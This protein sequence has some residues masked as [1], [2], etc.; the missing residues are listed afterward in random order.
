MLPLSLRT[1]PLARGAGCPGQGGRGGGL[2]AE[3]LPPADAAA[4]RPAPPSGPSPHGSGSCQMIGPYAI[5]SSPCANRQNHSLFLCK[6]G[7]ASRGA[8]CREGKEEQGPTLPGVSSWGVRTSPATSVAQS[9]A[10]GEPLLPPSGSFHLRTGLTGFRQKC[11]AA[12]AWWTSRPTFQVLPESLALQPH[13]G[14]CTFLFPK[15]QSVQFK[16]LFIFALGPYSVDHP[17]W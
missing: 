13:E 17:P 6:D 3:V 14:F 4:C 15:Q 9:R 16:T 10:V 8:N 1:P 2:T 5:N 11:G 7:E 12:G